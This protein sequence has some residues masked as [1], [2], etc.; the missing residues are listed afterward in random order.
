MKL[1]ECIRICFSQSDSHQIVDLQTDIYNYDLARL[2]IF[3]NLHSKPY[4]ISNNTES[5]RE[6]YV[7]IYCHKLRICIHTYTRT[8][9]IKGV[10]H[11]HVT[12][13]CHVN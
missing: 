3:Y 13:R 11:V 1:I 9:E 4:A 5:D 12:R 6:N 10:I 2:T 8:F 7:L